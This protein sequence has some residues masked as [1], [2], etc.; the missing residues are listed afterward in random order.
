MRAR[1]R[2]VPPA[3]A[4]IPLVIALLWAL[5][6]AASAAVAWGP[7]R[8]VGPPSIW[9]PGGALGALPKGLIV[10]WASDCPPPAGRCATDHGPYLGVF[11]QRG[12]AGAWSKPRRISPTKRQAE[13]ASLAA[14]EQ[15]V[16]AGFV[17]QTSYRHYR[18]S[19]PRVLYVRRSADRGMHWSAAVRLSPLRGRVDYPTLALSGSRAYAAWTQSGSGAIKL[20]TSTDRGAT[21]SVS[22]IGSTTARPDGP[23]GFAGYPAVGASGTNVMVAW[24]ADDAGTQVAKVSAVSGTDLSAGS[25]HEVLANAGPNDGFH[26][27]S[28]RGASDGVTH[29]V[30]VAYTTD[31]GL[32]VRIFD[33]SALGPEEPVIA[34]PWP[35]T[36]R[37][38][39]YDGAYGPAV[40]P[41][42]PSE[43]SLAFG[44]CRAGTIADACDSSRRG[45][46]VDL[47]ATG[48]ADGGATWTTP[49][50]L[51]GVAKGWLPVNES[52]SLVMT[53][54]NRRVV[55]WNAR[56]AR[57]LSYGLRLRAG[58]G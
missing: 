20:A 27:A 37:G 35:V 46:R 48:S 56:D 31:T 40:Q 29:D 51:A 4:T 49:V 22:T 25:P 5:A 53:R 58:V 13:R 10:A 39:A 9:N 36:L 2:P 1:S 6:P 44:A 34:G 38:L 7:T 50:R 18:S 16:I 45:A 17:T 11:V 42:G 15:R 8:P 52:P 55:V 43:L 14:D 47:Y 28:V 23:E 3:A 30:A 33:G 54:A 41:F 26:Y 21:W 32:A 19:A 57:F 12:T 24:Y